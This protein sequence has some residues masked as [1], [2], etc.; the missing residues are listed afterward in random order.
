MKGPTVAGLSLLAL[1]DFQV[2]SRLTVSP[3][4]RGYAAIAVV[5]S[6]STYSLFRGLMRNAR[7]AWCCTLF[8]MLLCVALHA[9]PPVDPTDWIALTV[10]IV[11][12]RALM[13][14]RNFVGARG[15]TGGHEGKL[16]PGPSKR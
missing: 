15:A 9:G 14:A 4:P 13:T 1:I 12:L 11:V 8:C 3:L 5:K 16:A 2:L 6:F 10:A 7:D